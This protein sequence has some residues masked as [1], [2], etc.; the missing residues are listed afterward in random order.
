MPIP[1]KTDRSTTADCARI[2]G[3]THAQAEGFIHAILDEISRGKEVRLAGLG[4]FRMQPVKRREVRSPL[5][6]GGVAKCPER[7]QIRFRRSR[8]ANVTINQTPAERAEAR[9]ARIAQHDQQ[10]DRLATTR[11]KRDPA[12]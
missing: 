6:P 7:N 12:E 9:A 2:A 1:P 11:P 5:M 4:I 3:L 10:V 8:V